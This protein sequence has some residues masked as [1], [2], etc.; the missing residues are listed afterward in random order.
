M[1]LRDQA[2]PKKT[3]TEGKKEEEKKKEEEEKKDAFKAVNM[4]LGY[5]VMST[6]P[7]RLYRFAI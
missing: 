3:Q 2:R 7:W 5:R 4:A 6:S 1:T